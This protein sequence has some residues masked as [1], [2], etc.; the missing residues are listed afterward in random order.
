M[1]KLSSLKLK[2]NFNEKRKKLK[3]YYAKDKAYLKITNFYQL[4]KTLQIKAIYFTM[5]WPSD[6]K[7]NFL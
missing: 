1:E 7:R 4:R 2:T 6:N 3:Q 5:L